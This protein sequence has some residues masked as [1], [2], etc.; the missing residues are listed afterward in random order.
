MRTPQHRPS[1]PMVRPGFLIC[2]A[3]LVA[4][5]IG[6]LLPAHDNPWEG[7]PRVRRDVTGLNTALKGYYVEYGSSPPE[8]RVMNTHYAAR[9]RARSCSCL[10]YTSDAADE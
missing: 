6:F 10:L 4:V 1:A 8:N 7:T 3:L 2:V 9:T 5:L